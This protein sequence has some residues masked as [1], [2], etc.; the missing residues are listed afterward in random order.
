MSAESLRVFGD[1]TK[2]TIGADISVGINTAPSRPTVLHSEE[3][4]HSANMHFFVL[5]LGFIVCAIAA[6]NGK[7]QPFNFAA[8]FLILIFFNFL[9]PVDATP[10][11]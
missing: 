10:N 4:P 3:M 5:S 11:I 8:K 6:T 2:N 1:E 7:H 9:S